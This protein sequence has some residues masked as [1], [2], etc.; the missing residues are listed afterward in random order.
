MEDDMAT[1]MTVIY[2]CKQ[3]GTEVTVNSAGLTSIDPIYCCGL[4]LY[5][6]KRM[7]GNTEKRKITKTLSDKKSIP[8]I[9]KKGTIKPSK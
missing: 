5:K 4:P 2:E 9:S 1:K 6:T 8:R 3:C 7:T